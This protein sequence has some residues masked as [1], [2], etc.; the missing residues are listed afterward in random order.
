MKWHLPSDFLLSSVY[1]SCQPPPTFSDFLKNNTKHYH[2]AVM[3]IIWKEWDTYAE[4]GLWH[5]KNLFF[6]FP[7]PLLKCEFQP[8]PS[9]KHLEVMSRL[10]YYLKSVLTDPA[11]DTVIR[12][13]TSKNYKM[14]TILKDFRRLLKLVMAQDQ[15]W[16]WSSN[17][18]F[19]LAC[20][21]L[22]STWYSLIFV[23]GPLRIEMLLS[24]PFCKIWSPCTTLKIIKYVPSNKSN[25]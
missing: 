6:V 10:L 18:T 16:K 24:F 2:R 23:G 20:S 1:Y 25:L 13:I 17:H 12:H 15:E 19:S 8:R 3:T 11:I 9:H 21:F 14:R 4:V 22:F 5:L 7:M